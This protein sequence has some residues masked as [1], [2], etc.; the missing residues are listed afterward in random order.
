MLKLLLLLFGAAAGAAGASTW[1]LGEPEIPADGTPQMA[2]Q[3]L[4][5]R[6]RTA[7][8]R[9]LAALQEGRVAGAA[10]EARLRQ[11]LETYRKGNPKPA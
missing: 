5:A 1:L 7:Q 8:A 11:E 4:Q 3:S 10:T 6:V 9:L 2:P